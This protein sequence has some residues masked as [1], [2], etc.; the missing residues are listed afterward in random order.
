[1]SPTEQLIILAERMVN[2]T[3][4]VEALNRTRRVMARCYPDWTLKFGNPFV[5]AD[6]RS[7]MMSPERS[8]YILFQ[9][10]MFTEIQGRL[11]AK[12]KVRDASAVEDEALARPADWTLA[13]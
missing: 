11:L 3:Q 7:Q 10:R 6:L 1:M 4:G 9:R 2:V 8:D 13:A 12:I 5:D